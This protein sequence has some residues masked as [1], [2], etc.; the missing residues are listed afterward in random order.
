MNPMNL[1]DS[2]LVIISL[3]ELPLIIIYSLCLLDESRNG[4]DGQMAAACDEGGSGLTV[5]R[6]LRLVRLL[7]LLRN[8][9]NIRRQL[10]VLA[11]TFYS[12]FAL[13]LLLIVFV[14]IAGSIGSYVYGGR[15][16]E[17]PSRLNL[18]LGALVWISGENIPREVV[19]NYQGYP[20]RVSVINVSSRP[21]MPLGVELLTTFGEARRVRA[22]QWA[23]LSYLENGNDFTRRRQPHA[24][25]ASDVNMESDGVQDEGQV[26]EYNLRKT[27]DSTEV[28]WK[29]ANDFEA[30]AKAFVKNGQIVAVLPRSN[31][32]DP[33]TGWLAVPAPMPLCCYLI[34]RLLLT[35]TDKLWSL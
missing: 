17:A 26:F 16:T 2:M 12:L 3:V 28:H 9:P 7:R 27:T 5:L 21:Q 11:K 25:F 19:D 23:R 31:F 29:M 18:Y 22:R 13:G 8:V 30:D 24:H 33:V 10:A 4:T 14:I 35:S 20:A 6:A 34:S 32:A 1:F 15:M